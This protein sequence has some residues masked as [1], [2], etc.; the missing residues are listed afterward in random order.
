[1][2][3]DPKSHIMVDFSNQDERS[4]RIP[5]ERELEIIEEKQMQYRE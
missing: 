3:T 2:S 4:Y 1:M 5:V